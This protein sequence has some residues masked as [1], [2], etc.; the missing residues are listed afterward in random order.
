MKRFLNFF[1]TLFITNTCNNQQNTDDYFKNVFKHFSMF[2]SRGVFSLLNNHRSYTPEYLENVKQR[3]TTLNLL[4][5]E[6]RVNKD[7]LSVYLPSSITEEQEWEK[8]AEY[9]T[10]RCT[11]R[12]PKFKMDFE[13]LMEMRHM[14]L[15]AGELSY[16]MMHYEDEAMR[17]YPES[18]EV[19]RIHDSQ[20]VSRKI[21]DAYIRLN[22]GPVEYRYHPDGKH[23]IIRA[24][25]AIDDRQVYRQNRYFYDDKNYKWSRAYSDVFHLFLEPRRSVTVPVDYENKKMLESIYR[26]LKIHYE[27]SPTPERMVT[28]TLPTTE[29]DIEEIRH[30]INTG[31]AF[32]GNGYPRLAEF[33]VY[34]NNYQIAKFVLNGEHLKDNIDLDEETKR[35]LKLLI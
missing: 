2:T 32:G 24:R 13:T 6:E 35:I 31:F 10:L 5:E 23:L 15:A 14:Y 7:Y 4:Y 25:Y 26:A 20:G 19:L 12:F 33:L 3:L 27:Y 29:E 11:K 9:M 8:I 18:C 16:V 21:M 17:A 1:P 34:H 28:L 22:K 30:M